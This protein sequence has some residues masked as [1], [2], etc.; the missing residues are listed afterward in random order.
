[1]GDSERIPADLAEAF[2][3]AVNAMIDWDGAGDEPTVIVH[4]RAT[5]VGAIASLVG[6]YKDAMPANLYW[7]LVRFAQRSGQRRAQAAR[8]SEDGSYATG[9][10]CMLAWVE[11][12]QSEPPP[13]P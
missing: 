6:T 9:A 11:D 10:T 12:A 7:R 4:G 1:M 5:F 13:V 2:D 3:Q 8:L